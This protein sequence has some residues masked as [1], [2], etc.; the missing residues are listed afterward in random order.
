MKRH[1]A[2]I[3]KANIL[4]FTTD[5]HMPNLAKL[6]TWHLESICALP[7]KAIVTACG[8]HLALIWD[9]EIYAKR[10]AAFLADAIRL[11]S[12]GA[13]DAAAKARADAAECMRYFPLWALANNGVCQDAVLAWRAEL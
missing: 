10:M 13:P 4:G 3:S 2:A 8:E 7:D 11:E 12:S 9:L 1:K 6:E 5:P